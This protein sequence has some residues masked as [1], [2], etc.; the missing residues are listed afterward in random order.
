MVPGT[1]QQNGQFLAVLVGIVE[2]IKLLI[3]VA[4]VQQMNN[5]LSSSVCQENRS[6]FTKR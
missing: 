1:T 2:L 5:V 4:L 6:K 3:E